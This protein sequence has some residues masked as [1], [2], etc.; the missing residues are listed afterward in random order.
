MGI[1]LC[2]MGQFSFFL[3]LRTNMRQLS[4]GRCSGLGVRNSF[5]ALEAQQLRVGFSERNYVG[6]SW[7]FCPLLSLGRT[8]ERDSMPRLWPLSA[9]LWAVAAASHEA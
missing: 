4:W 5:H 1:Y 6:L 9:C 2:R 8:P 3:F 7:G